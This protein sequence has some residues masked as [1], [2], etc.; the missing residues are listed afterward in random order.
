[1]KR[2]V[3]CILLLIGFLAVPSL[4]RGWTDTSVTC[5]WDASET[6]TVQGYKLYYGSSR[7]SY[8]DSVDVGNVLTYEL[9]S[10]VA[11]D[12]QKYRMYFAVTAYEYHTAVITF[13]GGTTEPSINDTIHGATSADIGTVSVV[14]V[15]SGSWD[16]DDAA[17]SITVCYVSGPWESSEVILSAEGGVI[18]T[19]ASI[20]HTLRESGYSNEVE[21]ILGTFFT[22]QF[23]IT[24]ADHRVGDGSNIIVGD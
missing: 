8:S 20:T 7:G 12:G 14:T 18:G 5:E 16:T 15:D 22:S 23:R 1:M 9:T 13:S 4:S 21:A 6:L 2:F 24:G 17:G 11:E 19:L 10:I 3:L